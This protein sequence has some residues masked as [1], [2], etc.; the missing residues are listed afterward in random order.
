[1]KD[2]GDAVAFEHIGE[3]L[4]AAHLAIV[5]KQHSVPQ[6]PNFLL[7]ATRSRWCG[8]VKT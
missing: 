5:S 4:R 2:M 8:M 3:A 7:A 6:I 1:M